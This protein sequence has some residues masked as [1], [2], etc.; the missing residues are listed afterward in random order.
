MDHG[1]L[2]PFNALLSGT[3]MSSHEALVSVVF[4]LNCHGENSDKMTK[5]LFRAF[6][7]RLPDSFLAFIMDEWAEEGVLNSEVS[8]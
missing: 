1:E 4:A 6:N 8:S 2:D 7:V 3:T 5:I